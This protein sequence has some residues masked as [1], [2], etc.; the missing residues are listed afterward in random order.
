MTGKKI[1]K[2]NI[3]SKQKHGACLLRKL[4]KIHRCYVHWL[5]SN[6]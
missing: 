3:P 1:R 5:K 2:M 6:Q 4:Q